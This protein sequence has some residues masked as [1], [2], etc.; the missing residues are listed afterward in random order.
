MIE[1]IPGDL[2]QWLR[3]FYFV[4]EKGSVTRATVLMGREQP[5]I[6]RQIKCLEKELGVT[7]FDR[8]SGKMKL[9][10][11]GRVVFEKAISLFENV[12][13][14]RSEF[15]KEQLE[16]RGKIV[17]AASH[18]IIDS[19]LPRYV[20]KFR[21]T[22]PH[23]TFHMEGGIVEMVFEKV[24]SAEA[25][26][27]IAYV[28]S[29]PKTM[30][31]YDLFETGLKLIAPKN[32]TFFP[33]K[34]PT[35]R[36]IAQAPL[37]LFSHAGSIQPFIER[38]FTKERLK[39]N[40]VMTHNNLVSVKKYVALGLGASLL[41]GYTLSKGDERTIDILPLDRYFQK[42][43]YGLLLRKKKYLSPAVKAFIRTIKP[44]IQFTN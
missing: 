29:V 22:H 18:A 43:K 31:C 7:L 6:T 30:V 17:I 40:V 10:P 5:T 12:K 11:E 33:D 27:G 26:L 39:P 25:D 37:I 41:N 36:Q 42:R 32:N 16:C 38:R 1:E 34:T 15:R 3:G 14:I 4:A 20:L 28:E 9:T 19:F 44:D 8:S 24:E 13:E 21:S 35:L 23:V 2:L